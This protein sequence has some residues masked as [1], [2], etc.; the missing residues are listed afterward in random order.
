MKEQLKLTEVETN[1]L[2]RAL[3][4]ITAPNSASESAKIATTDAHA[5]PQSKFPLAPVLYFML[6]SIGCPDLGRAEK[7]AW[8]MPF[9]FQDKAFILADE[10]FGL[11]LYCDSSILAEG[12]D[13]KLA[14]S[15]V[16]NRLEKGQKF[17][18]R[19]VLRPFADEQMKNGEILVKNQ[20]GALRETY[21]YF[22]QG[23]SLA[24]SGQGRNRR[25]DRIFA[26]EAEGFHNT[27][28]M[29]SAYFSLLE[30]LLVL[31]HPFTRNSAVGD[32][33]V[34]F[35]G[36][37]WSAKFREV[38]DVNSDARAK[39]FYDR[40]V[41]FSEEYRNTYAHGGF[42]KA[43]A[44]VA[45]RIP[46]VA[47]LPAALSDVR[48][49]PHYGLIPVTASEFSTI[50]QLLDQFDEWI[51]DTVPHGIEWARAGLNVS[52]DE[53][54]RNR[55]HHALENGNF[56]QF[57]EREAHVADMHANMDY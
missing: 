43:R 18:E 39:Y 8:A 14:V 35:I 6:R 24:Y 11:R 20:Y 32:R 56:N 45:F 3:K 48:K 28:A 5:L 41:G 22:R 10:K 33:L 25:P 31:V 42:D 2:L 54:F 23:A 53:A 19:R 47:W 29:I 1:E 16:M 12:N 36:D 17:I 46:G 44:T 34:R 4:G 9:A 55:L 38:F 37:R 21:E 15:Q 27:T 57:I 13:I 52:F 40:L 30:H 7:M 49:S 50:C 51:E 26:E